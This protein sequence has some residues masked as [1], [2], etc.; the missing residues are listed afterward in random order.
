MMETD[1]LELRPVDTSHAAELAELYRD[2]GIAQRFGVWSDEQVRTWAARQELGWR[3]DGVGKWMAY[4]RRTGE[5][6]G[7]GGLSLADVDGERR[8]EVGW[9]VRRALWGRG[10]ATE[11]GNAGITFARDE[12][13]ADEVVAFTEVDNR[14]SR[15]VMEKLGMAFVR[16]FSRSELVPGDTEVREFRY[17]L[18]STGASSPRSGIGR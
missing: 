13:G 10:F 4:D 15:A 5:L 9:A 17:A 11:I 2:P 14:A 7:R 16:E 6:V 18:Y 3:T 1:R 12:L 8:V